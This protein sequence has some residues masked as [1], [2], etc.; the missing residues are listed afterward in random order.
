MT[1]QENTL[2][3]I[4]DRCGREPDKAIPVLQAIQQHFGYVPRETMEYVVNNSSITAAQIYGVV[5]FYSQFRLAPVG[6]HIVRVCH[7]TACYVGG[8]Q[9]ISDAVMDELGLSHDKDTT[10]DKEF[11]VE[12]VACLG[13]C[14]LAPVMMIDSTAYGKLTPKKAREIFRTWKKGASA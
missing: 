5:T 10:D 12:E 11:T 8:A 14:S 3:E 1:M 4:L 13:C 2:R 7:G 9:Q 6:R